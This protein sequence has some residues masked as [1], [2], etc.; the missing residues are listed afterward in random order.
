MMKLIINS[1]KTREKVVELPHH[2]RITCFI[3]FSLAKYYYYNNDDNK[4][5]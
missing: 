4:I 2:I 3:L 1:W 5:M